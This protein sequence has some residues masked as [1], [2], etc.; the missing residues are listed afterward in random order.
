MVPTHASKVVILLATFNGASYIAEQLASFAAQSYENWE[1]LVSDDGSSDS[2]VEIIREFA[3]NRR[4]RIKLVEGPRQG[5][6]QNFLFLTRL[7][8]E[9]TGDLF[10][11]SDQDDIWLP[12]KIQRAVDWFANEPSDVPRLYF[13]RT[14]LIG[15]HAESL[16][17]SPLFKRRP[18]FQ[19]ALVQNIGGGNT[20]VLNRTAAWLL[21]ATPTDVSLVAHD[22]WTYQ[23]V[24]GA[25]GLAFYDPRPSVRYR[26]HGANLIGSNRGLRRRLN[27]LFAFTNS[28]VVRWNDMN[29]NALNNMRDL[30]LAKNLDVLDLFC[31]ART[32]ALPRRLYLFWKSGI[33]RQN[34]VETIG[35]Y[36]GSIFHLV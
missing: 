29:I 3:I 35:V 34:V 32:A 16:G 27:R 6:W 28:R 14:Q 2:T 18:S 36:I 7:A 10:A 9:S 26:Q 23:L 4:Q 25:G 1:L 20:M 5:F 22:W 31:Q 30:L 17:S 15:E 11:F 24:T 33:Y 19:N 13:T 8:A 21:S 12:T